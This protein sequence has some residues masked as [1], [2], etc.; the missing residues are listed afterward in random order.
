MGADAFASD[1]NPIPVLLNKVVLEYIPKYGQHLSDE[2]RKCGEW[3]KKEAE[4]ELYRFYPKRKVLSS[5]LQHA[6]LLLIN[7]KSNGFGYVTVTDAQRHLDDQGGEYT[8]YVHISADQ[9]HGPTAMTAALAD[10]TRFKRD[11]EQRLRELG[12]KPLN[13]VQETAI[14]YLWGLLQRH[15]KVEIFLCKF[16]CFVRCGCQRGKETFKRFVGSE[17]NRVRFRRIQ[18]GST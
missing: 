15:Q 16:H 5:E 3:I 9:A 11:P 18:H 17:T 14:A 1:L 2:V 4:K 7:A 13:L 6:P 8:H 12:A 10:S